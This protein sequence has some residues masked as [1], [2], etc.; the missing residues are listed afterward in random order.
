MC[1]LPTKGKEQGK[2]ANVKLQH[3]FAAALPPWLNPTLS[4]RVRP[5]HRSESGL[6]T[7]V[8]LWKSLEK[9]Q[10]KLPSFLRGER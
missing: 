2:I 10:E 1:S 5:T 7:Q 4:L 3:N 9:R 6:T 8:L